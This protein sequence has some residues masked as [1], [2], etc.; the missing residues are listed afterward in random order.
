MPSRDI[1]VVLVAAGSGERLGAGLPKA[2][3]KIGDRSLLEHSL[4]AVSKIHGLKSVVAVLPAGTEWMIQARELCTKFGLEGAYLVYGG[5][6]R[7]QS[8]AAGLQVL[9]PTDETVL[10]HDVARALT[11]T[12]LFESVAAATMT[13][14]CGVLPVL[15]VADTIK[16]LHQDAVLDT[17]D[18]SDLAIAQ[19]PQG[20]PATLIQSAYASATSD[21]TDDAALVQANGGQIRSV[22]GHPLA[23][24]ITTAAD[25]A[26]AEDLMSAREL[27]TGIGTDSHR[28][29]RDKSKVL[30]LGTISWPGER[31]LE[32]HSDGDAVSH[33]IVDSLLSAAGLGDIGSNFGVDRPEFAGANGSVF[34]TETLRLLNEQG[35]KVDNVSVQLI[36]NR[37]KLAPRRAEVEAALSRLLDAPVAL[38]ATTT[39]GLGF[40]GN[41]KG[42]AA[43]AT[44][45][46]WRPKDRLT[47]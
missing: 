8:I 36:G 45:L 10:I 33:A 3:A 46:I 40:L 18:R 11:P 25:L 15:P 17:V 37:P 2:F 38:G 1:A 27:R 44:A 6:T 34:L 42:L 13:H 14:N 4:Q 26:R 41:S 31:A 19:T 22:A 24:K 32:G 29:S 47:T 30:H 5:A 23:F 39:D 7:Q 35:W 16:R 12:E 9:A 21:F 43:V 20:F 28:F